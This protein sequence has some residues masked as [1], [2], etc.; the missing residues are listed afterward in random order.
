MTILI[1]SSSSFPTQLID[2]QFIYA[3]LV[4]AVI[5]AAVCLQLDS[6]YSNREGFMNLMA[7]ESEG[8]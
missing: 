6:I 1:V 5:V 7:N 4:G 8:F 3:L 2:M